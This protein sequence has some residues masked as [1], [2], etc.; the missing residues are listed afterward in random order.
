MSNNIDNDKINIFVNDFGKLVKKL[1]NEAGDKQETLA[2][3]IGI[4]QGNSLILKMEKQHA[5]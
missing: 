4:L 5:E 3:S 2:Y 1:R